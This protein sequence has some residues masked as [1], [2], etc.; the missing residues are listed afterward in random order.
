MDST[1][2]PPTCCLDR[3]PYH[4]TFLIRSFLGEAELAT[5][6]T[7]SSRNPSSQHC[8]PFFPAPCAL[9]PHMCVFPPPKVGLSVCSLSLCVCDTKSPPFLSIPR[10][11]WNPLPLALPSFTFARGTFS[12]LPSSLSLLPVFPLPPCPAQN[13]QFSQGRVRRMNL[14]RT[15]QPLVNFFSSQDKKEYF[16]QGPSSLLPSLFCRHHRENARGKATKEE[17]EGETKGESSPLASDLPS[18]DPAPG[19]FT[20]NHTPLLS[21]FFSKKP[22][23]RKGILEC[24]LLLFCL[25]S[26]S[27]KRVGFE[28]NAI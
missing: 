23:R 21:Y 14:I 26:K 4:S 12:L 15:P 20:P 28:K 16:F 9:L 7:S 10:F 8:S 18:I 24:C 3:L 17:G 6:P 13:I 2:L 27:E 25:Q 5:M 19:T 22:L 11:S 1:V